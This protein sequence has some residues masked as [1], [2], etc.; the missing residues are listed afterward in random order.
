M[1][2]NER[3]IAIREGNKIYA[4]TSYFTPRPQL[5]FVNARYVFCEGFDRGYIA[6]TTEAN[7]RMAELKSEVAELKAWKDEAIQVESEWDCQAVAEA[8]NIPL[9]QSIRTNIL[10]KIIE[11]KVSNNHLR[12]ALVI[13]KQFITEA[14]LDDNYHEASCGLDEIYNLRDKAIKLSEAALSATP[15][16][17]LRAHD[18]EV[19]EKCAKVCEGGNFLTESSPEYMFAKSAAKAIRAIKSEVK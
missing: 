1:T 5:D 14:I 2:T 6:A 18:D 15:A 3:E 19:I 4:E 17:S 8:L 16:E 12:E 11:L 13:C 9:G 7:K 10:P